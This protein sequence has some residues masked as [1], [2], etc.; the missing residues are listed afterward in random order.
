MEEWITIKGYKN[1][2]ISNLGRVKNIRTGRVLKSFTGFH[3]YKH[4]NL[5]ECGGRKQWRIHRLV[6]LTFTAQPIGKNSINHID[7]DKTNNILSNLEWCTDKEN[8]RHAVNTGLHKG[9][10]GEENSHSLLKKTDV[11]RI[12]NLY[13]TKN[14]TQQKIANEFDISQTHVSNI[15]SGKRWKHTK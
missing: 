15:V 1:Y 12:K 3:G 6:M 5:S 4:V 10:C 7:G 13:E 9:K 8:S 2:K 14:Y 11:L